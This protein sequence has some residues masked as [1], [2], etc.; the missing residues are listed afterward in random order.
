MTPDLKRMLNEALGHHQAGRL[1][2]AEQLYHQIIR[3]DPEQAEPHNLLGVIAHQ[4]GRH[5]IAVEL[6]SKAIK[7]NPSAVSFRLNLGQAL[8]ALG[9]REE[10]KTCLQKALE[11]K[12][13][14][15]DAYNNLGTLHQLAGEH[16][17]ASRLYRE[18]I[19]YDHRK[20]DYHFNLANSLVEL[21]YIDES[22][23]QYHHAIKLNPSFAYAYL[24]LGNLFRLSGKFEEA[25]GHYRKAWNLRPDLMEAASNL[26]ATLEK[27]NELDE[28]KEV[29]E[30]GLQLDPDSPTLNLAMA[31]YERRKGQHQNAIER[32]ERVIVLDNSSFIAKDINYELG[33]LYD[34]KEESKT[35]FYHFTRGNRLGV[36]TARSS[37]IT[38]DYFL[39][40][41]EALYSRFSPDWI[42]TW[43]PFSPSDNRDSPIFLLGFP[44]SGNTLLNQR[45]GQLP[46]F[47]VLE[48]VT[49][50]GAVLA[51]LS[52][53]PGGFPAALGTLEEKQIKELRNVYFTEVDKYVAR[54][55]GSL[56]IDKLPINTWLVP[57]IWRLFPTA[58]IIFLVR[59]P[60]DV[61]LSCYMQNFALNSA[62][63]S[64]L[65]MKDTVFLYTRVME[66][67]RRYTAVLPLNSYVIK[68]ENLIREFEAETRSLLGFLE[69][70]WNSQILAVSGTS[71]KSGVVKTPSYHQISQPLYQRSIGRWQ[72][73]REFLEPYLP[74]L[75]PFIT[76]FGYEDGPSG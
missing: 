1:S 56:L 11:L 29:A 74:D 75:E 10:A 33:K 40:K 27:I 3:H 15:A 6:I 57:V 17:E 19:R 60:A 73:Y 51:A 41:V 45:L 44:R 20:A 34:R 5:D 49:A 76:A 53:M 24:N 66:L 2:E 7:M 9:K 30:K 14:Y 54:R 58:M 72:R 12:P 39:D 55:P 4:V 37:G 42:T 70:K 13:D 62:M 52:S 64:F 43:S 69:V 25:T 22:L 23:D 47:Q 31:R 50:T 8:L 46:K 65:T 18:A 21:R 38:K 36:E 35:A 48:E 67:W 59:H 28:V 16:E 61:C 32:L 26:A 68:Y 63:C 71:K